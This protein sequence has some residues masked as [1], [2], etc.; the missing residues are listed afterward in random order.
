[1]S[2]WKCSIPSA[3]SWSKSMRLCSALRTARLASALA[4]A[5][6]SPRSASTPC[7]T[8]PYVRIAHKRSAAGG[9]AG[10]NAPDA[11]P[12]EHLEDAMARGYE[13]RA[14]DEQ[15][16]DEP[17]AGRAGGAVGGTPAGKRARPK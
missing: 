16:R 11:S 1:M 5:Q 17:Q 6:Q 9:L 4:A 10:T 12:D 8:R 3:P 7:L 15:Q 13:D 14:G 2:M